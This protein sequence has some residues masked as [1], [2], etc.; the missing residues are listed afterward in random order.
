MTSAPCIDNSGGGKNA[1][2]TYY[3][4]DLPTEVTWALN[5]SVPGTKKYY[6]GFLKND[7]TDFA[8]RSLA[9][10]GGLKQDLAPLPF[11]PPDKHNDN[12]WYQ[13][14]QGK[15]TATSSSWAAAFHL[16]D[17]FNDQGS[18]FLKYHNNAKP[19][20]IIFAQ[21][22]DGN[23][24]KENFKKID[25]AGVITV[26][27]GKNIYIT[28]HSPSYKNISLFRQKGRMSW[29][30]ASRHLYYWIVVPSRKV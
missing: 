13:D 11:F 14:H 25:H 3:C 20:Y 10:A 8:S 15:V 22:N 12:Y 5:H 23:H 21:L 26:V 6:N 18:Y 7:C 27:H 29:F 24:S 17:F 28:Q 30:G 1:D 2:G 4:S 16:A 9:F 19:G